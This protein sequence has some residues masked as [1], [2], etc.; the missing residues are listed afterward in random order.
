M[1]DIREVQ[2]ELND[3]KARLSSLT[4]AVH[5]L[6]DYILPDDKWNNDPEVELEEILEAFNS[7]KKK[8]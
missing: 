3:I 4:A 6:A 1:D 8:E 7:A 2:R 5:R